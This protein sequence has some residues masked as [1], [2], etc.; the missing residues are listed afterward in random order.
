MSPERTDKPPKETIHKLQML[1][2]AVVARHVAGEAPSRQLLEVWEKDSVHEDV[3]KSLATSLV[4]NGSAKFTSPTEHK[5]FI[6]AEQERIA[7][8]AYIN[9]REMKAFMKA[10]ENRFPLAQQIA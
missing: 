1:R 9:D 2:R 10:D 6:E 5:A 4:R 3:G 8:G 7:A